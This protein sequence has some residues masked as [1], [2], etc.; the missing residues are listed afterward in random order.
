MKGGDLRAMRLWRGIAVL[1]GGAFLL[2][3]PLLTTSTYYMHIINLAGISIVAVMGL[4]LL[5]GYAGQLS[6]GH[7]AICSIGAYS[8]ALLTVR[9][10][11]SF[12]LAFPLSGVVSLIFG[13]ILGL[14]TLRLK[15]HYLAVATI[16]FAEILRTV[17]V[18]WQS[19]TGGPNGIPNLPAPSI[20]GLALSN[21]FRYYYLI[22]AVV[23]ITAYVS[24]RLRNSKVGRALLAIKDDELAAKA[25]GVDTHYYKVLAFALS[26]FFGGLS[27]A[28]YAHLV[29]FIDPQYAAF[30][31]SVKYLCMLFIGGSGSV[32]GSAL[33]AVLLT[34]LPEWLRVL[35]QYYMAVYGIG[36]IFLMIFMP[37][38]IV[39]LL[40]KI[41]NLSL[42]WK[43]HMGQISRASRA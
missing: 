20:G 19:L 6:L 24:V 18:N 36:V 29:A 8:S 41:G 17:L 9:V 4:N 14:P 10:G 1:L 2:I 33:G 27:G 31:E 15:A 39:G 35:K 28:L 3:V 11:L 12:W 21:G 37:E 30:L 26:A 34:W 22:L 40:G 16:G 32:I 42:P 43:R 13:L 23:V 5:V 25:M 7:A 38:G